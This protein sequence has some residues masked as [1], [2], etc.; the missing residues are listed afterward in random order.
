MATW[1]TLRTR[2]GTRP[3]I[4]TCRAY[5]CMRGSTWR[6]AKLSAWW[7]APGWQP[8]RIWISESLKKGNSGIS[9]DS[10]CHRL[11]RW[12]KRIGRN[13]RL[14]AR[15]GYPCC[16]EKCSQDCKRPKHKP[17]RRQ[18]SNG[19]RP[20][21]AGGWHASLFSVNDR[22][23][24]EVRRGIVDH[25][26]DEKR[27]VVVRRTANASVLVGCFHDALCDG[28]ARVERRDFR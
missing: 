20:A 16:T 6:L 12:Q 18:R 2:T 17:A 9:R 5:W 8:G 1:C 24:G 28:V 21:R 27:A 4:C 10:G 19:L 14:C 26:E 3:T 7:E 15:S 25:A 23:F 11:S 22:Q 13:L